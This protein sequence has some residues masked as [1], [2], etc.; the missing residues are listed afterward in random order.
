MSEQAK[1]K[2]FYFVVDENSSPKIREGLEPNSEKVGDNVGEKVGEKVNIPNGATDMEVA[3]FVKTG[4]FKESVK[5]K[6][7]NLPNNVTGVIVTGDHDYAVF[8][9][10]RGVP[11]I[12]VSQEIKKED[13]AGLIK[14]A[15]EKPDAV[16]IL[17][18]GGY[19]RIGEVTSKDKP[20]QIRYFPAE[21]INTSREE[22]NKMF[23]HEKK[24]FKRRTAKKYWGR[25]KKYEDLDAEFKERRDRW[26]RLVGAFHS[27]LSTKKKRQNDKA[28][29]SVSG[30]SF[31]CQERGKQVEV[32]SPKLCF[33][34]KGNKWDGKGVEVIHPCENK[35]FKVN[36]K[37]VLYGT[38]K[39]DMVGCKGQI[40]YAGGLCIGRGTI[41]SSKA[42][43]TKIAGEK[44]IL[45]SDKGK[46]NGTLIPPV[47]KMLPP[48][49]CKC[50]VTFKK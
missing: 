6:S 47:G 31:V 50:K 7:S 11:A 12:H 5:F 32:Y 41:G 9:V 43:K 49:P 38:L 40:E 42:R 44:V 26:T 23:L 34:I 17:K 20:S 25:A 45:E 13:K 19:V 1:W 24:F 3:H 10:M 48:L 27:Q 15:L 28:E 18:E 36:G 2:K 14:V 4:Q 16:T 30:A 33:E 37:P 39:F 8:S 35:K 21:Q 29:K 46:C 22:Y